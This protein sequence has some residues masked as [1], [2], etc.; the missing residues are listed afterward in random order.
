LHFAASF[1][2][3][4]KEGEREGLRKL[5]TVHPYEL[6]DSELRVKVKDGEHEV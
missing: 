6:Q 5:F 3:F 2:S 4:L 1:P